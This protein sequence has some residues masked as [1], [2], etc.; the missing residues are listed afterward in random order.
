MVKGDLDG[1]CGDLIALLVEMAEDDDPIAPNGDF[2]PA[3]AAKPEAAKAL[4][5]V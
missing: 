2:A 5:E 3:K 1:S 4:L